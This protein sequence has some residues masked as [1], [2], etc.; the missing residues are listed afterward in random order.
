MYTELEYKNPILKHVATIE[1]NTFVV[2]DKSIVRQLD[3]N[4]DSTILEESV[5]DGA[6]ILKVRR[7]DS[8]N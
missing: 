1:Q 5:R 3:I 2:I 4:E 6:I 8:T 7:K